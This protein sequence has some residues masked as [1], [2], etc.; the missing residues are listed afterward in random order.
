M[1]KK[2]IYTLLGLLIFAVL[3]AACSTPTPETVIV[4][5]TVP[6]TVKE[7][8]E[9]PVEKT[10]VKEITAT[11][12]P[13][14]LVEFGGFYPADSP[15][16]KSIRLVGAQVEKDFPQCTFKYSEYPGA[17]GATAMDLRAKDGNPVDVEGGGIGNNGSDPS[18]IEK[19]WAEGIVYDE[20]KDMTTPA[21]GQTSGTW[22]DTFNGAAKTMMVTAGGK[23]GTV[24]YMQTQIVLY[25]NTALYEKYNLQPPKTWDDFMAN[26]NILKKNKIACIGGGGFNGYIGYWYDMIL[27]RLMGNDKQNALYNRKDPALKWTDAEPIKAA[28]MLV[29]MIKNG[30]TTDGFVG[31]DFTAQQVAYFQGK[32]AHIFV[33][34]WL[35]GEMKDSV[36]KD[37]KQAVTFFPTIKGYEDKTP[38]EAAFGFLNTWKI[39]N[40]GAK[41]KDTHSTECAVN[42]VKALTSKENQTAISSGDNLDYITTIIGGQGKSAIPGIGQL[43]DTMKLWFP[44]TQNIAATSAE[45]QSKYWDNVTKLAAGTFTPKQFG[46]QMQKDWDDIFSR[47]KK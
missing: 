47:L 6:V 1:S 40:T 39:N 19:Q 46:E 24:P 5:E 21:Y 11:P 17:D 36:P 16:G 15:W 33:G 45:L 23:I 34:T 2:K 44:A 8:V 43:L 27:F 28:E 12:I 29:D 10:V 14:K 38:Y 32:A 20:A 4:K 35:M 37:F 30:Y 22:L 7:T 26:C 42:F 18:L 9:V 25:Y 13:K 31:G 41:T 3:V